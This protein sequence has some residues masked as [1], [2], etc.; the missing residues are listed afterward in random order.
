MIIW[1]FDLALLLATILDFM[2]SRKISE[3]GTTIIISS[4]A[5]QM[6]SGS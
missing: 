5:R 1:A 3:S 6:Y 2:I 4:K